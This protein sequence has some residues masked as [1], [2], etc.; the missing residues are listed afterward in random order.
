MVRNMLVAHDGSELADRALDWAGVVA[1]AHDAVVTLLSVSPLRP[2]STPGSISPDVRPASTGELAAVSARLRAEAA[3]LGL[4]ATVETAASPTAAPLIVSRAREIGADLVVLG[5]HGRGGVSRAVKGSVADYVVR[6]AECPVATIRSESRTAI[7]AGGWTILAAYDFSDTADAA[8]DWIATFASRLGAV[9]LVHVA[10]L[11][12]RF[13][14]PPV[15]PLVIAPEA[16]ALRAARAQLAQAVE[17]HHLTATVEVVEGAD[18]GS[19]LAR[20]AEALGADLLVTGSR[21]RGAL[22]RGVLGS[23]A[24]YL[25]RRAPCAVVTVRRHAGSASRHAA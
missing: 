2:P 16:E 19:T 14:A 18:A 20:R 9:R 15:L 5:T 21:G 10:A 13:A 3:R 8:L 4:R 25:L 24:D 17:R 6:H 12:P 23:V 11:I 7:A 22:Q 1:R